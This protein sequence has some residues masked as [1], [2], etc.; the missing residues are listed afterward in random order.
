MS[1]A[2]DKI[3]K[4]SLCPGRGHWITLHHHPIFVHEGPCR[5]DMRALVRSAY[6][7]SYSSFTHPTTC[8]VCDQTCFF[9]QNHHGSK[10]FFDSLGPPWPKHACTSPDRKPVSLLAWQEEG[11]E[12][13]QV[14]D[15]IPDTKHQALTLQF[16]VLRSGKHQ[17]LV[18]RE[19]K[20]IPH[21]R[22]LINHPFFVKSDG[23]AWVLSTFDDSHGSIRPVKFSCDEVG[24][25]GTFFSLVGSFG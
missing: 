4:C 7:G 3:V 11:Y 16:V 5:S 20:D 10:V 18:L 6:R 14:L 15:A 8:P 24:Y 22:R 13:I 23:S 25:Q 2:S 12:P 19:R 21:L 17:A 1:V 9:Y